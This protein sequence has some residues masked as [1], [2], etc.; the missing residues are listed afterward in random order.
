[1]QHANFS[2]TQINNC[3][4]TNTTNG[5]YSCY[6]HRKF[7]NKKGK[8][9]IIPIKYGEMYTYTYQRAER[10]REAGYKFVEMWECQLDVDVNKMC[11]NTNRPDLEHCKL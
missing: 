10:I 3:Y 9:V 1:M 8:E 6:R 4:K 5:F 7:I 11:T 2:L